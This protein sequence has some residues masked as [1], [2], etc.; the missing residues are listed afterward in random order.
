MKLACVDCHK[1]VKSLAHDTPPQKILCADCHVDAKDAY[2]HSTH[3]KIT[4]GGQN[5]CQLPG[6]SRKRSPGPGRRRSR[7]AGEP[8]QHSVHMRALPRPE[9][10]DGVERRRPRS[11]S[12]HIRTACTAAPPKKARPRLPSAPTATARTQII[13]ANDAQSPISKFN[14]PATC[15]KCHADITQTFNQSI[16]GQAIARGNRPFAR[17]HGLPRHSL[18]QGSQRSQ[19]ARLRAESFARHLRT[20]PRGRAPLQRIRRARQSRLQL[21]GQL[22]RPRSRGRLSGRC[23][24]LELPRRPQHPA[25]ER[26]AL[27]HQS[28]QPRR[29]LRQVSQ[30]C[31]AEIHPDTACIWPMASI[32]KTSVQS[33]TR[34]VRIIYIVLIL[35]VIGA[36]FLHNVIIWRSK[37]AAR[38]RTCR[39]R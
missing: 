12:S 7:F 30:G 21:H 38:R 34:W 18:H 24:L 29:H 33:I 11:P 27:H 10:P 23:K 32:R 20:L 19:F 13:P 28:G 35:A 4:V 36:M 3:A 37:A 17:L 22:P 5:R 15:G 39:T 1:D 2:A 14:V 6:L 26:S 8:R 25:F 9:I 16:H 31:H